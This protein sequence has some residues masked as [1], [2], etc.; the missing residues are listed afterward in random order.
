M[1][2]RLLSKIYAGM[3]PKF[4]EEKGNRDIEEF[5]AR[6]DRDAEQA[7]EVLRQGILSDRRSLEDRIAA[8]EAE[9]RTVCLFFVVISGGAI[10][11]SSGKGASLALVSTFLRV[12]FDQEVGGDGRYK[13]G[14]MDHNSNDRFL[15]NGNDTSTGFD[16]RQFDLSTGVQVDFSS[17]THAF[18]FDVRSYNPP[19]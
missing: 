15:S 12:T 19:A 6:R 1:A 5:L 17:G 7:F 18:S 2:D 11:V 8:L 16:L 10:T 14:G 13:V 3:A 4:P 9:P